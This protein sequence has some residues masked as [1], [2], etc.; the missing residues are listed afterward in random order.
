MSD[1]WVVSAFYKFVALD[2]HVAL[3]ERVLVEARKSAMTGSILL[4]GEGINGTV[5]GSRA[6]TD[7]FFDWLRDD[8]RFDDLSTKES[9]SDVEPFKRMKVR[10]KRE[11]VSLRQPVDPTTRVGTYV[12]PADWN[13]LISDPDVLVIDTR[14][15]E[16]I[17]LGTFANAVN[18]GTESFTEFA[19]FVAGLDSRA[20]PRVA[21][22]CTGGI[23]CEKATS[24]MLD[25]GFGEVFHLEGGILNYLDKVPAAETMWHG[26][27]FVFDE[28]VSV[29]HELK[30]GSYTLCRGCRRPVSAH[31]R[32]APGYEEG[33]SCAHCIDGLSPERR[34]SLRERHRQVRLAEARGERHIAREG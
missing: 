28:R 32:Q 9:S 16:E 34:A 2:D 19:G 27:C 21:M 13:D 12:A 18:P 8:A 11:I 26:E 5:A 14:N 31:E 3:R 7:D 6:A 29:D 33:V 17:Q 24:Y 30:P 10:L 1:P 22:F 23:R 15:D 20:H 25:Q 4:A